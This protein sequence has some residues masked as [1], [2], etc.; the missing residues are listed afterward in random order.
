MEMDP[1]LQYACVY[2]LL[3]P[4]ITKPL[5]AKNEPQKTSKLK[6]CQLPYLA[7]RHD[8]AQDLTNLTYRNPPLYFLMFQGSSTLIL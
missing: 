6:K 5:F 3:P 1:N 8:R 2:Q 7:I 4:I